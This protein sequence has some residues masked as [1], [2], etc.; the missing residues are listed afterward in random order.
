MKIVVGLGNP[1]LKY[2]G[3]RHNAGFMLLDKLLAI[4][5]DTASPFDFQ[6]KFEAD[7]AKIHEGENVIILVKPQSFMNNSGEAVQKLVSFYKVD[8]EKDMIVCY[9]DKDLDLGVVKETG[10]SA[11]GHKGMAS[12]QQSLGSKS[13]QRIRLGI[14]SDRRGQKPTDKFVLEKFEEEEID[15]LENNSFP[16]ALKIAAQKLAI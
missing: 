6:K 1:G 4:F 13:I 15:A 5:G 9:D 3:T 16:E 8:P 2:Q 7:I 11:G 14:N 12:I 10:E